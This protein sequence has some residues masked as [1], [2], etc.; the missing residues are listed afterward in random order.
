VADPELQPAGA[1]DGDAAR[2][3]AGAA[4]ELEK[5]LAAVEAHGRGADFDTASWVWMMMLGVLLPALL[6][7]VGWWL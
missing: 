1:G 5:R 6:L 7:L 3:G 2:D 4:P